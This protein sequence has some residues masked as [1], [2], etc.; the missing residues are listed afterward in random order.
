MQTQNWDKHWA[1]IC[2][3]LP[4]MAA[5]G[6]LH[7]TKYLSVLSEINNFYD[8]KRFERIT[9]NSHWYKE[10]PVLAHWMISC[11][12]DEKWKDVVA[13]INFFFMNGEQQTLGIQSS[14]HFDL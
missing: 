13:L 4:W 5:Y 9:K 7:Y 11:P 6:T 3:M 8:K 12:S 2:K 14:N 1:S 10:L